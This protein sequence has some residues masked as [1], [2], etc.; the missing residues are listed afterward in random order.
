[1]ESQC[2]NCSRLVTVDIYGCV[3]LQH[4]PYC[5]LKHFTTQWAVPMDQHRPDSLVAG[6]MLEYNIITFECL[7]ADCQSTEWYNSLKMGS[8]LEASL[9]GI[10]GGRDGIRGFSIRVGAA[11]KRAIDQLAPGE[12]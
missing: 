12:P 3:D 7:L 11:E 2:G 4:D 10:I 1:M 6:G 9:G 5:L 8:F